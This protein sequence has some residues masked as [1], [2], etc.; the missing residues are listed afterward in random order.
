MHSDDFLE[1]ATT[2]PPFLSLM[3]KRGGKSIII[4][5]VI[6]YC[7]G[8]VFA[9]LYLSIE[10]P[11]SFP[12]LYALLAAAGLVAITI[13]IFSV[14]VTAMRVVGFGYS[15]R[16]DADGVTFR[17]YSGRTPPEPHVIPP[18]S[19]RGDEGARLGGFGGWALW[20]WLR[21]QEMRVETL[22]RFGVIVLRMDEPP[23]VIKKDTPA[24]FLFCGGAERFRVVEKFVN[25]RLL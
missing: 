16:L 18:H 19:E 25:D 20:S 12:L 17:Y 2:N 5:S 4:A 23:G 7:V 11:D 3:A 10:I 14:V 9:W 13:A 1:W 15:Y 8:M 24:I 22:E 6:L 21:E